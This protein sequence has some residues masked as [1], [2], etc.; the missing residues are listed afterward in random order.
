M[1]SITLCA[2]EAQDLQNPEDNNYGNHGKFAQNL[3]TLK[4]IHSCTLRTSFATMNQVNR[5]IPAQLNGIPFICHPVH[6]ELRL[7]G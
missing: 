5:S 7:Q 4:R 1:G 2:K 6:Y 3:P